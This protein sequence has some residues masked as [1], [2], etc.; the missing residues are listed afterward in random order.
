MTADQRAHV[1]HHLHEMVDLSPPMWVACELVLMFLGAPRAF[2]AFAVL[3]DERETWR[4]FMVRTPGDERWYPVGLDEREVQ[5][6]MYM[7]AM[8]GCVCADVTPDML[9]AAIQEGIRTYTI[10]TP[11]ATGLAPVAPGEP[12]DVVM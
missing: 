8:P 2:D 5:R 12:E 7:V 10:H 6:A 4:A 11:F 9:H 1:I 3:C